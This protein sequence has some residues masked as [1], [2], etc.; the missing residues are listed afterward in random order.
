MTIARGAEGVHRRADRRA[1]P[2]RTGSRSG[3]RTTARCPTARSTR[4]PRSRWAS[5]SASATTRRTP[6]SCAR[7]VRPGGR[8]LVQQM[9]RRGPAPR[10]RPVHRVVHRPG[11][12]H[13][14]GRRDR[15]RSSSAAASRCATC[16]RCASTTC[17]PSTRWHAHLRGQLGPAS[18]RW[19]A[20]RSPASG[21]STSS[22]ARWPSATAGWASTR[23]SLVRPGRHGRVLDASGQVRRVVLTVLAR[24]LRCRQRLL[25]AG[26][27]GPDGGHRPGGA[28][29][30]PG[31]RR[32][33]R[34][35][36]GL[37]RG[38]RWWRAVVGDGPLWRR[39]LVLV[40]VAVWGGRLAWHMHHAA[41]GGKGEDP[42]Y[43]AMLADQP[44]DPFLV[45][46]PQGLPRPGRRDLVR[47]A[48]RPGQRGV[49]RR[50]RR[51]VAV[52]G[53]A[54]WLLGVVFE[55]VGD[56]QLAAFKADAATRARSWTAGCGRWTRHPNYFGDACV[57]WGIYLVA[58]QRL[59]RCR[60]P[61]CRRSS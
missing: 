33:H 27:R 55:A 10:R 52:L 6:R 56:A 19:S 31:Q 44:G 5:T 24:Q 61:S 48:A 20:R 42:R 45:R 21:G 14:A 60:S 29:P 34:L 51:L 26:R 12:A 32:R 13:A 11:H 9:S 28:S 22:A 38:R 36:A 7:A 54:V 1:R 37:R 58:R 30:G 50:A 23:S 57:W 43:E 17:A 4:S 35:G 18:S 2:A 8:V 46:G 25:A 16:T 41:T 39:L 15:R 47:L 49:R 3:C 53:A 40:L 59:A